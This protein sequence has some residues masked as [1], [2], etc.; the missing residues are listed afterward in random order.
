MQETS[1]RE[2]VKGQREGQGRQLSGSE[3]SKLVSGGKGRER[4]KRRRKDSRG[5]ALARAHGNKR[6]KTSARQR[7]MRLQEGAKNTHHSQL[8]SHYVLRTVPVILRT[9]RNGSMEEVT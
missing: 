5:T 4:K 7:H 2:K 6:V 9:G 3:A 8:S 1:R